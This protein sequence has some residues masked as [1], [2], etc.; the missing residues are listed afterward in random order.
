M[1]PGPGND[2]LRRFNQTKDPASRRRSSCGC[3]TSSATRPWPDRRERARDQ[4]GRSRGSKTEVRALIDQAA[5]LA[6]R[7]GRE[8]EVG[9]INVIV[10]NLVGMPKREDLMLEYARKAVAMLRPEDP[11]RLQKSTL[12]N[13]ATVLRKATMIDAAKTTAE[14]D[15][16]DERIADS[17]FPQ[18]RSPP[19]AGPSQAHHDKGSDSPGRE[20][21]PPLAMRPKPRVS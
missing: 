19:Q 5:R 6:A 3:S 10:K 20:S 16:L 15:A 21:L 8:M 17:A 12:K 14:A 18:V 1:A 11:V 13:M 7:Y 9:E 4:G 2:D